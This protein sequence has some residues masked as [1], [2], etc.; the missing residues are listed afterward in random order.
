MDIVIY[1]GKIG[2]CLERKYIGRF[3]SRTI[4]LWDCGRILDRYQERVWRGRWGVNKSSRAEEVRAGRKNSK[5]ICI[6]VQESSKRKW[7]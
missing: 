1:M 2:G 6:R 7:L 3:R 5:R 4:G